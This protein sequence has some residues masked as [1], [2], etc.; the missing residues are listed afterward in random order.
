MAPSKVVDASVVAAAAF[1]EERADEAR[2]LLLAADSL[3]APSLLYYELTNIARTKSRQNPNDRI[4]IA[5]RLLR[6]FSLNITL[7][8][9][10]HPAV[11]ELALEKN[12]TAYDASY[13]AL[14]RQLEAPLLTFDGGL[15]AAADAFPRWG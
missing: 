10:D 12:L 9:V 1:E 11:L 7:L 5:Q 14:A 15:A 8:E 6:A 4:R 2:T 13:V 3:A